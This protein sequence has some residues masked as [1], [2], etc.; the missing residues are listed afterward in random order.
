LFDRQLLDEDGDVLSFEV[1]L[2]RRKPLGQIG[3]FGAQ[4]LGRIL[5]II[6]INL[7]WLEGFKL[8]NILPFNG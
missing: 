1:D 8:M 6:L 3:Q 5:E 2:F 4:K 7:L